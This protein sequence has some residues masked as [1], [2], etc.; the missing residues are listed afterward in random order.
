MKLLKRVIKSITS[1]KKRTAIIGGIF[2]VI[3][4]FMITGSII[5]KE[6]ESVLSQVKKDMNSIVSIELNYEKLL[7]NMYAGSSGEKK[8]GINEELVQKISESGYVKDFSVSGSAMLFTQFSDRSPQQQDGFGEVAA[9]PTNE[10]D[11]YDSANPAVAKYKINIIEGELPEGEDDQFPLLISQKYAEKHQLKVGDS[12]DLDFNSGFDKEKEEN[13]KTGKIT[14]IYTLDKNSPAPYLK[15]EE[16]MFYSNRKVLKKIKEMQFGDEDPLM[17]GYGKVKVE[18]KN[19]MDT[20]KFLESLDAANSKYDM[21]AFKSS[22]DQYQTIQ[23]MIDDFLSMLNLFQLFLII[24][25]LIVI[26][27]I[28][29]LSLRERKYEIGLLLALGETKAKIMLQ[30]FLEISVILVLSSLIGFGL[31]ETIVSP[32][33]STIVNQ[34]MED[35]ISA[36]TKKDEGPMLRGANYVEDNSTKLD[37]DISVDPVGIEETVKSSVIVF[38]LLL[39]I[40]LLTTIIPTFGIIK[41]SPKEILSGS[42]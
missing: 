4:T 34:Q 13:K 10:I 32:N 20:K 21:I 18:L 25:G 41:K 42:E 31:S 15:N 26:G 2:L 1:L 11:I 38:S 6:L 33:A 12:M 29:I 39:G 30:I 23:S 35:S 24:F 8:E 28:M 22:Y 7:Q 19:P 9:Y 27:L 14:G 16:E 37:T 5:Q 36:M 17:A 40:T 3:T